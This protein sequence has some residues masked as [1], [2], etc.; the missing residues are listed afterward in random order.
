MTIMQ[1]TYST[2][3]SVVNGSIVITFATAV[4]TLLNIYS[5]LF[6]VQ[7]NNSHIKRKKNN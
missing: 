7:L 1:T 4:K 3:S 5:T 2:E 6:A